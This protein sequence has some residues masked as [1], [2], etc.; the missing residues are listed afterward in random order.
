MKL[1]QLWYFLFSILIYLLPQ[2]IKFTRCLP[3]VDGSL[4]I[5]RL[6]STTKTGRHDIAQILLKVALNTKIK[7]NQNQIYYLKKNLLT[8]C[9]FNG[10][11]CDGILL[12]VG[13]KFFDVC[14]KGYR[15]YSY[16]FKIDIYMHSCQYMKAFILIKKKTISPNIHSQSCLKE[17][18]YITFP[19]L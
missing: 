11:L 7:S 16:L 9:W 17:H 5:L 12:Q 15:V 18:L 8:K 1:F 2:V 10:W 4:R 13:C 6:P 14:K 19:C 3:M